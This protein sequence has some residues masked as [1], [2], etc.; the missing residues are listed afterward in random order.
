LSEAIGV[1]P[2]QICRLENGVCFTTYDKLQK[3]A[4]TLNVE[5]YEFF[6]YNPKKPKDA[7]IKEMNEIFSSASD[8]NIER[9]YR[10]VTALLL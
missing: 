3:I 4:Q 7:L 10:V 2:I 8:E 5:L 1:D 9:I 6:K